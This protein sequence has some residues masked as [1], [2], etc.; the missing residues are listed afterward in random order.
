MCI[1]YTEESFDTIF[2]MDYGWGRTAPLLMGYGSEK[3]PMDERV[4]RRNTCTTMQYK[5]KSLFKDP[6]PGLHLL[7]SS[8]RSYWVL[9]Y[10]HLLMFGLMLEI[11]LAP[12]NRFRRLLRSNSCGGTQVNLLPRITI[13]WLFIRRKN[14]NIF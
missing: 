9:L 5:P 3:S 11:W 4:N 14:I 8:C 7:T 10:L 2:N 13:A 12:R 6:G 1:V